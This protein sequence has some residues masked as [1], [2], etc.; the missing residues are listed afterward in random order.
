MKRVKFQTPGADYRISTADYYQIFTSTI[1][2]MLGVVILLRSFSSGIFIM[3]LLVGVG[4]LALGI[5]RLNFVVKYFIERRK[6][7]HK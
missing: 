5:Y 3:P 1:M 4:F 2:L 6:C 7:S